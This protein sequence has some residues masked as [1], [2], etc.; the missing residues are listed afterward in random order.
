MLKSVSLIYFIHQLKVDAQKNRQLKMFSNIEE[1]S[2]QIYFQKTV[3]KR[4]YWVF[5]GE[6]GRGIER[7]RTPQ[8]V[9]QKLHFCKFHAKGQWK[10][11]IYNVQ[12]CMTWCTMENVCEQVSV[13]EIWFS[14][15]VWVDTVSLYFSLLLKR[16]Y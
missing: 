12:C 11:R 6:K 13:C 5:L 3:I 15:V 16:Y 9:K 10:I 8:Y 2:Y 4:V 7:E 14:L 1:N